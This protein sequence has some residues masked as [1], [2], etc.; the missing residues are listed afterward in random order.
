MKKFD[1]AIHAGQLLQCTESETRCLE[2]VLVGIEGDKIT[3]IGEQSSIS[4]EAENTIDA[5][6]KIV[7]PG[8]IN[9]HS[10][11]PMNLLRG[12]SDDLPL[13]RWL[14]ECILPT[15]ARL[16]NEEFCR[17]GTQLALMESLRLGSTCVYDMYY[18]NDV[19]A[20]EVDRAG[21]RGIIGETY[22]SFP[23]PDTRDNPG[24]DRK[25]VARLAEKYSHHP[26]VRPMIAPHS[27]YACTDEKLKEAIEDAKNFNLPI[28]IHVCETKTEVKGSFD[29]FSKSPVQ[30]LYDIGLM[31][32]EC[33]FAHGV[34]ISEE[35]MELVAQKDVSVIYNAESNMK[36]GSGIA[37]VRRF[38]DK[39]IT[40]GLGTDGCASNNDLNMY[41]EM[42]VA[43]KLQKVGLEDNVAMTA[44]DTFRL[45]THSGARALGMPQTG[46]LEVGKQADLVIFNPD[47]EWL[48][49]YHDPFSAIVY[50]STGTEVEYSFID[51]QLLYEKGDYKKLDVEKLKAELKAYMKKSF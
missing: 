47:Q 18:F 24:N 4:W 39:G 16:V 31:D 22:L 32:L 23:A 42:D 36:L 37:P 1:Y 10:H 49:P 21:F 51:G 20:D 19:I 34:H 30:R 40:V 50:S 38:L 48:I 6:E 45:A 12:L 27:P 9:A 5:R 44:K 13:E 15:E 26:R 8:L 29:N 11:L 3:F 46:S 33:I 17:L 7:L 14:H 35:E 25:I 2:N 41:K 28:G 43:T